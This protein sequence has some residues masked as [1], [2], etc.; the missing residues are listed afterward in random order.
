MGTPGILH[1]LIML[2]SKSY[3]TQIKAYKQAEAVAVALQT[4]EQHEHVQD[5]QI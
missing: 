2:C 1:S 4:R 3:Q 5:N